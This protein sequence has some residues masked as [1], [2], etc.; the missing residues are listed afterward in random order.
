MSRHTFTFFFPWVCSIQLSRLVAI[1]PSALFVSDI[2][3]VLGGC[4][5]FSRCCYLT[6]VV[7][8]RRFWGNWAQDLVAVTWT[9]RLSSAVR[10][11][12]L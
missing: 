7:S 12:T 10:I 8:S 11:E 6:I 4:S 2:R 1:L 3:P 5:R 9:R